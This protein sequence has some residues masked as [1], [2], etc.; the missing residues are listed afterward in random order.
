MQKQI[1]VI[2]VCIVGD[3][4]PVAV[5]EIFCLL[6]A[7]QNFD[8][9][10]SLRSLLRFARSHRSPRHPVI[11]RKTN[12]SAILR[13]CTVIVTPHSSAYGCHLLPPEKAKIPAILRKQGFFS[14]FCT[15]VCGPSRRRSLR[16][17]KNF[18]RTKRFSGGKFFAKLFSKKRPFP[19]KRLPRRKAFS[20]FSAR[21]RGL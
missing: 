8:R 5:P 15:L 16:H 4:D 14:L 20:F 18:V 13:D 17:V 7:T 9:C 10:H 2:N 11:R 12:I 6:F 3:G 19:Q 21:D 1:C